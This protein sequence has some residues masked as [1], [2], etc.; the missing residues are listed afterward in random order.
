MLYGPMRCPGRG[1]GVAAATSAG[2]A[3]FGGAY[4]ATI[5]AK[6]VLLPGS[7]TKA[8]LTQITDPAKDLYT[9]FTLSGSGPETYDIPPP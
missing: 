2:T 9:S 1:S 4:D 5:S 8:V 6:K 3:G 7:L